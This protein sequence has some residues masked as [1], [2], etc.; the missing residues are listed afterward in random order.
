MTDINKLLDRLDGVK[1]TG[2]NKWMA[3][4][5]AHDDKHASFGVKITEDGRILLNCFAG[6][7]KESILVSV[8]LE[9]SDLYP[10]K[11]ESFNYGKPA[12]KPPKFSAHEVVK[13][14]VFE[15]T[16]IV[17]AIGQLMTTGKINAKDLD[18]VN[19]AI[20]TLDAI[21]AE[22]NYGR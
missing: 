9:F 19:T 3:K 16:L 18:R 1:R 8:G 10:P 21:R 2:N 12:S 15:S 13:I 7:D 4:C 6:C 20:T 17:L 22:V 14:A 11:P 5:P